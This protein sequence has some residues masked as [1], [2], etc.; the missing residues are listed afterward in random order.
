L[1]SFNGG[2]NLAEITNSVF[3]NNTGRVDC[4]F[5]SIAPDPPLAGFNLDSDGSCRFSTAGTLTYLGLGPLQDNGGPTMTHAL[6]GDSPA[7]DAA[8][9]DCP[10]T[11]QRGEIRPF[12]LA[13]DVG[14]FELGGTTMSATLEPGALATITPTPSSS[15]PTVAED[16]LCWKGPGPLYEVVSSLAIGTQVQILGRGVEGDW[17]VLDNPR[18]PG[19]RCWTPGEDI[20]VLPNYD[21]PDT[22]FEIPPLPTPTPVLGCLYY[23]QQQQEACFPM[24]QCPVDFDDSLGACTP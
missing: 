12:G 22:L 9:G 21:Y 5:S 8:T 14:A 24:D 23:D 13:C 19:V 7:L 20:E 15:M 10:G 16:T 3:A 4:Y 6:E 18:Y 1:N 17:W 11:D 2:D